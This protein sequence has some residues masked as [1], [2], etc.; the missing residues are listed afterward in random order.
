[1]TNVVISGDGFR[2]DDADLSGVTDYLFQDLTATEARYYDD[3][4][5]Y[6]SFVGTGFTYDPAGNLTGGTMTKAI[7]VES[8]AEHVKFTSFSVDAGDFGSAV[9]TNDA[10]A[11]AQQ[12]LGPCWRCRLRKVRLLNSHLPSRLTQTSS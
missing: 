7:T 2:M 3:A 10:G 12:P 8:G 4:D 1:M 9:L 6:Q 11:A 5:N